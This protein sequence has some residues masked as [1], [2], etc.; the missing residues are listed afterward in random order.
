MPLS[1]IV[2]MGM[3]LVG[4]LAASQ[5]PEFAQQYEQRLGGALDELET[6]V[7]RFDDSAREAGLDREGAV[8]RLEANP[9]G[10]VRRQGEGARAA[11]LRL[12]ALRAHAA[13]L[14]AHDG[15]GQVLL[16]V[17]DADPQIARAAYRAYEP[18]VPVTS[19]GALAAGLGFVALWLITFGAGKGAKHGGRKS[20][21]AARA[22]LGARRTET[23]TPVA[24]PDVQRRSPGAPRGPEPGPEQ[25][26]DGQALGENP[27][28]LRRD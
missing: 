18:A 16:L 27:Y 4:A 21:A 17:R 24:S 11:A 20:L 3:G 12:E 28:D 25:P 10:L 15:L 8:E 7:A 2:A 22:R 26:Q 14:A 19:E 5:G 13:R 1:R 23:A 9:D 6:V